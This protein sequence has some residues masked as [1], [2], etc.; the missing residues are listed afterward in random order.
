MSEGE[1][2]IEI[3]TNEDE[4]DQDESFKAKEIVN[5]QLKKYLVNWE[6]LA[7]PAVI[8]LLFFFLLRTILI[9][10]F[11]LIVIF[12]IIAVLLYMIVVRIQELIL[13]QNKE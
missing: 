13:T 11:V 8:F 7:V 5:K 2:D 6:F 3:S 4:N 1:T 10:E 9:Y 12:E